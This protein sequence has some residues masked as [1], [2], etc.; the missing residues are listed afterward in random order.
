[1]EPHVIFPASK[2]QNT[3]THS[4]LASG[5]INK[6]HRGMGQSLTVVSPLTPSDGNDS[7]FFCFFVLFFFPPRPWLM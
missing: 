1:M 3:K 7:F 2:K 5:N 6:A 4:H